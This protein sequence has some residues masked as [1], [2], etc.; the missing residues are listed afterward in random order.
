LL[1]LPNAVLAE[2]VSNLEP[3]QAIFKA[4]K[5]CFYTNDEQEEVDFD[6]YEICTRRLLTVKI[7]GIFFLTMMQ[8]SRILNLTED[9]RSQPFLKVLMLLHLKIYLLK[10]APS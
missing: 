7:L 10:K 8:H 5:Y 9:R 6:T 4:R 3:N 2:M 1:L